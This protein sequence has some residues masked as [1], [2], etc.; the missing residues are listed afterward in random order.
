MSMFFIV[1]E[2]FYEAEDLAID[3]RRVRVH[4]FHALYRRALDVRPIPRDDETHLM[5]KSKTERKVGS[6]RKA[7]VDEEEYL[8]KS[9]T[10]L[11]CKLSEAQGTSSVYSQSQN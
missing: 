6:G 3:D 2:E 7:T 5:L 1:A 9:L 4:R 11:A 10:K 8:L